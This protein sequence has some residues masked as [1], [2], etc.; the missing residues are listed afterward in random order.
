MELDVALLAGCRQREH[1]AL[2]GQEALVN[3]PEGTSRR[4]SNLSRL[5]RMSLR[6]A[7]RSSTR[8][9]TP[10]IWP[11]SKPAT[12]NS[13]PTMVPMIAFVSELMPVA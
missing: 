4:A 1:H 6:S 3:F 11:E 7:R 12:T 5:E 8:V 10:A 9:F 13:V 2:N